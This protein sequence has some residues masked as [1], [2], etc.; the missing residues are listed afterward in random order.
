MPAEGYNVGCYLID[1][2]V[3]AG[4]GHLFGV[5][6]DYNLRFLDD[7]MAAE[8][9]QWVGCANELNAAYSADGYARIRRI[10]ALLTTYGVGELSAVNG[11]AGAYAEMNPV[12]HIVGG[13][14][15]KDQNAHSMMHHTLG[16]GLF[17]HFGLM[18]E[19]ISCS[20]AYL[21]ELHYARDIDKVIQDVL[22]EKRPGYIVLPLDVATA[23][24]EPPLA[25][26]LRR[27]YE[28]SDV[29]CRQLAEAVDEK[30]RNAKR[31]AALVGYHCDRFLCQ[32]G[33]QRL[34]DDAHIPFAH[35]LL[36]KGT[37]NEQSPN[38]IGCYYG[39]T[40]PD[41]L[42]TTVEDADVCILVGVRFH[43][44]GT[45]YF[46]QKLDQNRKIEI[47]PHSVT[48]GSKHYQQIPMAKALE[49]VRE[50]ALKYADSWPTVHT[51]PERIR[52]P[53]SE[54]FSAYHFW[55]E[56]QAGL[57][58][59]DILVVDQG[60]S[61][62]ATAGL[63]MPEH[64]NVIV[65]CLWGSIGYSIPAAFGAQ[66]AAPDRRVILVV[67]D[68]SAQLTVQEWGT[69]LRHDLRSMIFLV[70]NDGYVIE[71]VIHGWNAEYNDIA[72]WN[73]CPLIKAL[74]TT[75]QPDTQIVNEPGV[76]LA[77]LKSTAATARSSASTR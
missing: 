38:Y 72:A 29:S 52:E 77:A 71:R 50:V 49:I 42:R 35:M 65:Q 70:N 74:S 40:S 66:M 56:M 54:K 27:P 55:R 34:V 48:I 30:L 11:V 18:S 13:P 44:F 46:T 32:E 62:S 14:A 24:A 8:D 61:S 60:T 31:P 5:P 43:D 76:A 39:A 3:E 33:A 67:G 37:L 1:R 68:G 16:D 26:L 21:R 36:G 2:L 10:G 73:W 64:T 20:T 25:P 12:I 47:K 51:K 17:H 4:C 58:P 6:G 63:V 57:Q 59:N 23:P 19:Q 53:T 22:F 75:V 15:Q 45:G 41:N 28:L 7:V 69:F 9:F